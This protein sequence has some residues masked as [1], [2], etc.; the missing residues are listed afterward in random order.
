MLS[1]SQLLLNIFFLLFSSWGT[2]DKIF[3]FGCA[4]RW[5]CLASSFLERRWCPVWEDSRDE[6]NSCWTPTLGPLFSP[7]QKQMDQT[8][9]DGT[10]RWNTGLELW[11]KKEMKKTI[12][13]AGRRLNTNFFFVVFLL[14]FFVFPVHFSHLYKKK[15]L[16]LRRYFRNIC[17]MTY[18]VQETAVLIWKFKSWRTFICPGNAL[19][20]PATVHTH[21]SDKDIF[22]KEIN[23]DTF[24][25]H[26]VD[27]FTSLLTLLTFKPW[28]LRGTFL[29]YSQKNRKV[30]KWSFNAELWK[31]LSW[32]WGSYTH[33]HA[34]ARVLHYWSVQMPIFSSF[35]RRDI[36]V[37]LC[38]SF[39]WCHPSA[40]PPPTHLRDFYLYSWIQIFHLTQQIVLKCFNLQP[41]LC[42]LHTYVHRVVQSEWNQKKKHKV[43]KISLEGETIREVETIRRLKGFGLSS[44]SSKASQDFFL[45]L[46]G[47][48]LLD[49]I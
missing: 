41:L 12:V 19:F 29:V 7:H 14:L 17:K 4:W 15:P 44:S 36:N 18:F 16:C 21:C 3:P 39:Y 49:D 31:C 5:R 23:V 45:W 8:F 30:T 22:T 32:L 28:R 20:S 11:N 37:N 43:K 25:W 38:L 24:R 9:R 34:H 1:E 48:S 10:V 6:G 47:Q 13:T 42:T 40:S 26:T 27:V 33:T 35:H 2:R 46:S